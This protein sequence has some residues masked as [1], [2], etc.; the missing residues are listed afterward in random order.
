ML[1]KFKEML[2]LAFKEGSISI[3]VLV[4]SSVIML[5]NT[6]NSLVFLAVSLIWIVGLSTS[7]GIIVF[8]IGLSQYIMSKMRIAKAKDDIKKGN[9]EILKTDKVSDLVFPM[10]ETIIDKVKNIG[11]DNNTINLETLITELES[12]TI[13]KQ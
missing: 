11:A 7:M 9:F 6:P 2:K 12:M 5:A 4:I 13:G 8:R 3:I 10:I 1:E